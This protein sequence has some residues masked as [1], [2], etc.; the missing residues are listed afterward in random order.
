MIRNN[1]IR[2]CH[3][4]FTSHIYYIGK[5]NFTRPY[6]TNDSRRPNGLLFFC[7]GKKQT[8]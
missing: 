7:T 4:H 5:N 1:I 2:I 8:Q 6:G 3:Q